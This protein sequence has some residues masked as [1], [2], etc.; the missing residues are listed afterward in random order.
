[1]APNSKF[2][3]PINRKAAKFSWE[4]YLKI[5]SKNNEKCRRSS[6]VSDWDWAKSP[7][8]DTA[9]VVKFLGFFGHKIHICRYIHIFWDI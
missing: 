9:Y 2:K 5:S 3:N 1:M 4:A 6:D 7:N 8:G